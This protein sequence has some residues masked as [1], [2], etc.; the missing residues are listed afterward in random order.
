MKPDMMLITSARFT[1]ASEEPIGQGA[2]TMVDVCDDAKI[3]D[4]LHGELNCRQKYSNAQ[5]N[6]YEFGCVMPQSVLEIHP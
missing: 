1:N 4:A 6:A 3:P 5:A 2:F